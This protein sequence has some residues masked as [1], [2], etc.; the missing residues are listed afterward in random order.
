MISRTSGSSREH[1]TFFHGI[2]PIRTVAIDIRPAPSARENPGL[3]PDGLHL[4]IDRAAIDNQPD[5]KS[6]NLV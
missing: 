2:F 5:I 1:R 4:A 3:R 6:S